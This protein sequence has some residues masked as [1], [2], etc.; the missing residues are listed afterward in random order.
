MGKSASTTHVKAQCIAAVIGVAALLTSSVVSAGLV[1][2]TQ[3]SFQY[4][5]GQA[6]IGTTN[7]RHVDAN[8]LDGDTGTFRSLGLNGSA[9]FG[10]GT[11][12]TGEIKIWEATF[13]SCTSTAAGTCSHWPE[14][15]SV[16][17][18][19]DWDFDAP[20]FNLDFSQWTQIGELGN[21]QAQGGG[22]LSTDSVFQYLLL[23]DQGLPTSA[24][25]DGFDVARV[26]VNPVPIPAAGWLFGS[27]LIGLAAVARRRNAAKGRDLV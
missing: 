14:K 26:A 23:V 22:I 13:G 24:P 15:V 8:A 17:G 25:R 9:V 5:L 11:A 12:F 2:A 6:G 18:G 27:V 1:D 21:A 3:A 4:G 7:N 20:N 19:N 10:F 16:F